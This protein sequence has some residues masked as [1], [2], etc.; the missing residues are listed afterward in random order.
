M[1]LIRYN[2]IKIE[3]AFYYIDVFILFTRHKILVLLHSTWHYCQFNVDESLAIDF[4]LLAMSMVGM[5]PRMNFLIDIR[6]I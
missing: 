4:P 6:K 2:Q 5:F 3:R 1:D